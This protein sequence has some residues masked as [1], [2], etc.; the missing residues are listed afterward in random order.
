MDSPA[1]VRNAFQRRFFQKKG[2]TAIAS[3]AAG[4]G[5]V[6]AGV[7]PKEASTQVK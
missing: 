6:E 4:T 7:L 3:P 5:A 2:P 1:S